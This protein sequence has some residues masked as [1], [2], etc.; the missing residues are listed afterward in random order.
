MITL[1]GSQISYVTS[2]ISLKNPI[3]APLIK[4]PLQYEYCAIRTG[5]Y[6]SRI[7][8]KLREL[9]INPYPAEAL[10]VTAW[11]QDINDNFNTT[12]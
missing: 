10:S 12:R 6:T 8:K 4:Y 3:F 2:H 1:P 9:G 11:A 7:V 5:N